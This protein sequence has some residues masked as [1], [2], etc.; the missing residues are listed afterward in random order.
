MLRRTVT[1]D[2]SSA[3]IGRATWLFTA[4]G[5][6]DA[7]LDGQPI[8]TSVL[9]PGW[10]VYESRLAVQRHDVTAP[11]QD[12]AATVDLE[13]TLGRGWWCG[14]LGFGDVRCN[15]GE[16]PAVLGELHILFD[17]G[18]EQVVPT[19]ASWEAVDSVITDATV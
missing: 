4:H 5:L 9:D 2:R 6:Y 19:D 3:R 7:R 10:T 8:S 17:D 14:D 15:Y 12:S 13:I 18:H 1:L 16:R 11:L